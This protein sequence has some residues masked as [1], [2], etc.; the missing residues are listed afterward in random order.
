M[1]KQEWRESVT[2]TMLAHGKE[3][4]EIKEAIKELEPLVF[5]EVT[6]S[7]NVTPPKHSQ[8]NP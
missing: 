4:Y 5:A 2:L 1:T 3:P 7:V 6:I 8:D